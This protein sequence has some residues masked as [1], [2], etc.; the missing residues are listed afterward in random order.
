VTSVHPQD[1]PSV[2]LHAHLGVPAVD[3]LIEGEPGLA[4]Q[5]RIDAAAQGPASMAVNM[6]QIG[7]LGPRLTDLDLRL[8]AMDRGGMDIQ[9]V[10][11]V[12]LPHSWAER[13][14]AERI[15]VLSNETVAEF[16][17]KRPDRLVPIGTVSLQY[18]DLAVDQLREAVT[19]FGVRGVQ[20]STAAAQGVELDDPSLAEFWQAAEE[21]G[22]AVLIHPW[23][24][25]L[26]PRLGAYYL[27]NTVGNPVETALALSRI[28]FS[29]LLERH[30]GLRIWAAHGG[31][32]LPSYLVRADHAWQVRSDARTTAEPPS[33]QL[34]RMWVD[35]LVYEPHQLRHLVDVMGP[36]QVT[37][38]S[39]YP[40]DM[41]VDNP[42][43]RLLA[44]GFD[45][46]TVTAV[47]GGNAQRLL[48][49]LPGFPSDSTGGI[50]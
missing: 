26:G 47:R 37:L 34:R 33:A 4:R 16:C 3:A 38:G 27:F 44:A 41:G 35:S 39:D 14:L 15:A 25:S 6:E 46:A 29:G 43:E 1:V 22:A 11:A 12:P 23:G 2:D 5:R 21:L 40:F 32:Y 48:G 17:A 31:G 18:P 45:A 49:P 50:Q 9:A 8:E 24:C 28:A 42:V 30:P 13:D 20:I 19:S 36:T 7:S 10:S